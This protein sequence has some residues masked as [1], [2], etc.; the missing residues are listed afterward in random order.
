[1]DAVCILYERAHG[2]TLLVSW[3]K[4]RRRGNLFFTLFTW[5]TVYSITLAEGVSRTQRQYD[6]FRCRDTD[7]CYCRVHNSDD[8]LSKYCELLYPP[9]GV[10]LNNSLYPP[11]R[12]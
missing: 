3:D 10:P 1:M 6:P 7:L 12:Q 11:P 4:L 9:N 2:L 8:L 5:A